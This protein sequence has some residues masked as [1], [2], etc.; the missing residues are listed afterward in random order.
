MVSALFSRCLILV[1]GTLFPAYRSYKAI[2]NKDVREHIKWMMYW[3]VFALFTTLETFSDIFFS[4][5]PFYYEIKIL[6][7]LWILSP[8][9][10]GSSLLYK[11]LVHPLLNSR[12]KE[13]DELIEKTKQQGYTTFL[14]LFSSGFQYASNIFVNS[15]IKGQYFLGNQLKKSF[16]MNDV[17]T[18]AN[19]NHESQ[20]NG[21]FRKKHETITEEES[22]NS[23]FEDGV[24]RL[25]S[26][27]ARTNLQNNETQFGS[28][29]TRSIR[30]TNS[31]NQANIKDYEVIDTEIIENKKPVSRRRASA[32]HLTES[33][34]N[35]KSTEA[36]HFGTITRNKSH[37]INKAIS[38]SSL[39]T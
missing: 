4:W 15:A 2:K 35:Y 33:T 23:D 20:Q 31:N 9:T 14:Q 18:A 7:I 3:I 5:F 11:K 37:A 12:E 24:Q 22:E 6:F 10:R 25:R 38:S 16:S 36:A 30:K 34:A 1:L 32:K 29:R 26:K 39:E 8:A 19:N 17:M 13:I 28:L 21:Y 27:S